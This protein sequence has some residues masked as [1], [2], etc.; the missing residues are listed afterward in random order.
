M[1]F[2]G[3]VS[4]TQVLF[5]NSSTPNS[6]GPQFALGHQ[7][8]GSIPAWPTN[9]GLSG[10]LNPSLPIVFNTPFQSGLCVDVRSG[11]PSFTVVYTPEKLGDR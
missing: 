8:L 4:G 7:V 2:N 5:Y 6:G 9:T 1:P 11:C 10:A 3:S